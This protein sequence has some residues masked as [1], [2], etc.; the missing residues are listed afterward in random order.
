MVPTTEALLADISSSDGWVEAGDGLHRIELLP[1][2]IQVAALPDG[3][4]VLMLVENGREIHREVLP[5]AA[6]AHL[7]RLLMAGEGA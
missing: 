1:R 5:P 2:Q 3:G 4:R 7:A 6:A